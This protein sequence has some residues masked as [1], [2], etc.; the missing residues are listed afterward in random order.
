MGATGRSAN[1]IVPLYA[2]GTGRRLVGEVSAGIPEAQAS[3]ELVREL[4]AFGHYAGIALAVGA[5]AAFLLAARLK[6]STFGP[7]LEEIAGLLQ[8]REA[9]LHGIRE[10]VVGLDPRGR[11][12]VVN[13]EARRLLGLTG[14][15]EG[16][17][18]HLGRAGDPGTDGG[19]PERQ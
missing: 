19:H 18:L 6:R 8:D 10:G 5:A 16:R 15:V 4:P 3:G 7:E 14:D 13:D 11:I 12:T 17:P 1:G 2:P 9:T